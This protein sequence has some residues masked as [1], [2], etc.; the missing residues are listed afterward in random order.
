MEVLQRAAGWIKFLGWLE[1]IGGVL[2]F[3]VEFPIGIITGVIAI[4]SGSFL[5]GAAKALDN[6]KEY[7]YGDSLRKYF[8]L[9]GILALIGVI[10]AGI[11]LLAVMGVAVLS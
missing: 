4:V 6:N 2:A 9:Q 5:L 7:D 11:A 1:I 8:V 3:F 10:I